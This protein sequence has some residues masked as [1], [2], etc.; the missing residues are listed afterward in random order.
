M[1]STAGILFYFVLFLIVK[2]SQLNYIIESSVRLY[3]DL[4][5]F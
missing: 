5:F 3:L 1:L 2:T 4:E